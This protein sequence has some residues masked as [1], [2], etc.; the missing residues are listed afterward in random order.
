MYWFTSVCSSI[1]PSVLLLSVLFCSL[2]KAICILLAL[3][4][5]VKS[6]FLT[7]LVFLGE[8]I[9]WCPLYTDGSRL[10]HVLGCRSPP[11]YDS[12]IYYSW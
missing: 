6:D 12:P 7:F 3:Q 1:H 10:E 9:R 11:L 8:H 2:H 5:G 4:R